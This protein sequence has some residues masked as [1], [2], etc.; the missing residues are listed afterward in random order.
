LIGLIISLLVVATRSSVPLILASVGEVVTEKAG[1]VNIGIEGFMLLAGVVAAVVDYAT[2]SP[3]LGL[4][5]GAGVGFILG[6]IHGAAS[7][8]LKA[9]QI[10]LGIGINILA[11]GIGVAVLNHVWGNP[12]QSAPLPTIPPIRIDGYFTTPMFLAAIAIALAALYIMTRTTLGLE[13]SACGEDPHSAEALGVKVETLQTLVTA[14]AGILHGLAGAYLVVD[15]IGQFTRDITAGRGF[16]AL[17]IVV[18]SN[19][20]TILALAASYLLGLA[21]ATALNLQAILGVPAL[22]DLLNTLPYIAAL[23]AI[24]IYGVKARAP[25]WLG[26]PYIKE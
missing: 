16:I 25:A 21:E 19:W 2:G 18:L 5:A 22:S 6:L 7:A 10:V 9:N 11:F 17:A 3:L 20:N 13:I 26:R 15:Y 12:G 1:I 8:K 24:T 4:L 23:V 14:V